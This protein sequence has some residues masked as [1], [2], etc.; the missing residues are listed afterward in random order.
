MT[1][2]PM[3]PYQVQAALEGRL[4]RVTSPFKEQP[5]DIDLIEIVNNGVVKY[6]RPVGHPM[7]EE[8]RN[9]PG[10][11][12]RTVLEGLVEDLSPF[13]EPRKTF[14]GLETF[15]YV[16]DEYEWNVSTTVPAREGGL[17]YKADGKQPV[18][19]PWKSGA[20]MPTEFSRITLTVLRR[21]V[22]RLGDMAT[23][24]AMAMG[25]RSF[26]EYRM[27]A[28]INPTVWNPDLWQFWAEVSVEVRK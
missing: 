23:V 8:A 26:S 3:Q 13:P 21:G 2:Y 4:S 27:M 16:P 6:R 14:V 9:T 1:R 24:A 17:W 20:T 22:Q 25:Y 7:I 19:G 10:Y 28:G 11:S 12:V 18:I 5:E 15:A